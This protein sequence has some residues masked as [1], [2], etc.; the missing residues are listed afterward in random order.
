MQATSSTS[1]A[2][3]VHERSLTRV[4]KEQLGDGRLVVHNYGHDGMGVH[5]LARHRRGRS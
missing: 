5:P 4:E 1:L 2:P 3:I